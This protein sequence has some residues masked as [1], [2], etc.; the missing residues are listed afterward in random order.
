MN[1]EEVEQSKTRHLPPDICTQ[2]SP[3]LLV[4]L[5]SFGSPVNQGQPFGQLAGT[6]AELSETHL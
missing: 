6:S 4:A 5:L 2:S 3:R 1:V